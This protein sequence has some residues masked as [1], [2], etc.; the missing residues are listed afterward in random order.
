MHLNLTVSTK[1]E[2]FSRSEREIDWEDDDS[3]KVPSKQ[4]DDLQIIL[5]MEVSIFLMRRTSG[6][7]GSIIDTIAS[8]RRK[9]IKKYEKNYETYIQ[10]NDFW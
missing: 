7:C 2:Y 3:T 5:A 9:L 6:V 10:Y 8:F 1:D 4:A